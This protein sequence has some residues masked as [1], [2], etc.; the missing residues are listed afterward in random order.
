MK[1]YN[2]KL[3]NFEGPLDL[4]LSLINESK[5]DISEISLAKITDQYLHYIK[6]N[7]SLEIG[8]IADFLLIA[9]KLIYIKSKLLLP[10]L[11]NAQDE[12]DTKELERQLKIY[13][14]YYEA[15]KIIGKMILKKNFSYSRTTKL[16]KIKKSFIPPEKLKIEELEK[17]FEKLI[18]FIKPVIK[19]SAKTINRT[20]NIKE[21]I[22][23]IYKKIN[24]FSFIKFSDCLNDKK[25]KIE[26]IVSFLA[27][28]E[29]IKQRTIVVEQN[30][31][32][33]EI[34]INKIDYK[35]S[36]N[37]YLATGEEES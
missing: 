15:R 12:E 18:S 23:N 20:I 22:D 21:K 32:F 16:V 3:E 11:I 31:L 17:R 25:D 4:L 5:L 7:E 10:D 26:I 36:T 29:L 13:K 2:I 1:N 33:D 6:D 27:I 24:D 9:S 30:N 14:E 37:T 19:I 34:T 8:E 28:L 35:L